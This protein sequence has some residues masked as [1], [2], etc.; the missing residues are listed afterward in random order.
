M[1]KT[2]CG[3]DDGPGASGTELLVQFGPTL[4]VNVGFDP[5]FR[6]ETDV[7]PA[8]GIDQIRALVD[9]G[10]TESCIDSLLAAQLKLP[11]VD[12]RVVSGVHGSEEVQVHLAQVLVPLLQCTIYGMFAGVH[13][14]AGGQ[15]HHVLLGRTFLKAF[16]MVYEGDTGTVTISSLDH[17]SPDHAS[18]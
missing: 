9:T 14:Q 4:S 2:R 3:F 1:V 5:M 17:A 13:L 10:A 12:R 11:V 15:P 18:G 6:P 16:R 7:P 8:P